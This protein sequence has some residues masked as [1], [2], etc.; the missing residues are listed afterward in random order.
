MTTAT[1]PDAFAACETIT[2]DEARNFYYGIRLLPPQKRAALCS[3]YALARRIDDIGDE[4]RPREDKIRALAALRQDLQRIDASTD[5]VLLAVAATARDFQVPLEAFL[6]LID[7]VEMDLAD[8]TYETF[9]DLT[10]YCRRVAGSIGRLCL[11]VFGAGTDPRAP[12]YADQ[13]GIALQQTNILR[14]IREDLLIGRVYLPQ[15]ELKEHGITLELDAQG[16]LCDPEARLAAYIGF[17]A[18]RAENW[19]ALGGRL[20]PE[21]DSRSS[22]CCAAMSGIYHRLLTRIRKNPSDVY[23]SRLSLPGWEKGAVAVSALARGGLR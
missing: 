15:Q 20:L 22:A 3:L 21:L 18:A 6:E 10:V 4:D 13:L 16:S 17:A 19:Y 23:G 2:R 7:G 8:V 1:L 14:D 12:M 11:S 9:E 5:P